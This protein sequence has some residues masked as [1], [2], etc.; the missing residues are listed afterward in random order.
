MV[1]RQM[2]SKSLRWRLI[3]VGLVALLG[4]EVRQSGLPTDGAEQQTA[5]RTRTAVAQPARILANAPD[6]T[7]RPL[8]A[9]ANPAP[10]TASTTAQSAA[11]PQ[12]SQ[13]VLL[14]TTIADDGSFALVQDVAGAPSTILRKGDR[15]DDLL[16][17]GIRPDRL[18]L[19]YGTT[20]QQVSVMVGDTVGPDSLDTTQADAS[21][22]PAGYQPSVI[23]IAAPTPTSGQPGALIYEEDAAAISSH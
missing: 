2:R 1:A 7:P 15:I 12:R 3:V 4:W 17:T 9:A 11:P 22:P 21:S 8:P 5:E 18:E 20:G 10:R 6:P 23:G 14:G 19:A 16:V 13:V